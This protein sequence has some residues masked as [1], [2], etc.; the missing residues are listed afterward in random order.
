MFQSTFVKQNLS[1]IES[2][3]PSALF[4]PQSGFRGSCLIAMAHRLAASLKFRRAAQHVMEGVLPRA[5]LGGTS[6]GATPAGARSV[7]AEQAAAAPRTNLER[8]EHRE[9]TRKHQHRQHEEHGTARRP[10][11]TS[12]VGPSLTRRFSRSDSPTLPEHSS[13]PALSANSSLSL[14]TS[15]ASATLPPAAS[16]E[17]SSC[18][19]SPSHSHDYPALH[20]PSTRPSPPTGAPATLVLLPR[21]SAPTQRPTPT[22]SRGTRRPG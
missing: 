6:D 21:F 22:H 20:I 8:G 12:P 13:A 5:N 10:S 14:A 1:Q 17:P 11:H 16:A 7:S 4:L 15:P 3:Q 2:H 19:T 9:G 18:T